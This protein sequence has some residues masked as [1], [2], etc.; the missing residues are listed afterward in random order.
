MSLKVQGLLVELGLRGE[1]LG[2]WLV[3]DGLST[4]GN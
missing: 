4:G 1:R 2:I 3:V